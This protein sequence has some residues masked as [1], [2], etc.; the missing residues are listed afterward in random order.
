[1]VITPANMQ[2]CSEVF[3]QAVL[4]WVERL[5]LGLSYVRNNI[6][7]PLHFVRNEGFQLD[8]GCA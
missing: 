1:M 3:K 8:Q 4:R 6:H 5:L 7:D 2:D